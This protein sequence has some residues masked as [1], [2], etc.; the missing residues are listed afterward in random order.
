[1]DALATIFIRHGIAKYQIKAFEQMIGIERLPAGKNK[2][3]KFATNPETATVYDGEAWSILAIISLIVT[4]ESENSG[5]DNS[6]RTT[7]RSSGD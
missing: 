2:L 7:S 6:L 4:Y 5:I 1:M 3:Y